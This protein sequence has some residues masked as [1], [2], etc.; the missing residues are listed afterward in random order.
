MAGDDG[1]ASDGNSTTSFRCA[2]SLQ[3]FHGFFV[4]S[5]TTCTVQVSVRRSLRKVARVKSDGSPPIEGSTRQQSPVREV[6]PE[7]PA[8]DSA[9]FAFGKMHLLTFDLDPT[10]LL[11]DVLC[12][13]ALE[14]FFSAGL[15][16]GLAEHRLRRFIL[17]VRTSMLDNP[18]HNFY[19]VFDVMQTT[20]ALA[21][22]T[23]TMARLN[24]WERFALLSAALCH[25]MEHPGVSSQFLSKAAGDATCGK[26]KDIFFRDVLLEKHHS[27]CALQLMCDRDVGILEGLSSA[28]YY[29]FRSS[30]SKMILATDIT[31]HGEYLEHLQEFT[32][33]RAENPA[34]EMDKQLAMEIMVNG[35]R[36]RLQRG[37][38]R[39]GGAALG[40][41]R[42]GRVLPPRRR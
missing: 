14:M 21:T 41:S 34:V 10:T 29:Q 35:D 37:Q 9:A 2:K 31:R 19:H 20:N 24:A 18:Y 16:A 12:H 27:L 23:G 17:S 11:S 38:T 3:D 32:A 15:P 36:G 39:S 26:Y 33:R 5:K 1:Y 28:Q 30:V 25:D 8:V 42:H 7:W 40:A 6:L 4:E 13:L 22:A